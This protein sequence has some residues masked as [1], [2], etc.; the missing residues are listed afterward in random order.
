MELKAPGKGVPGLPGWGDSR[1][2]RQ[3]EALKVLPNV[4]YTTGKNWVVYH[5]GQLAADIA[6]LERD[7]VRA[8]SRLRPHS[9]A[10]ALLLQSFLCWQ[11]QQPRELRDMIKIAAG[12]C[13]LLRDEVRDTLRL[14]RGGQAKALF[15]AHLADWQEWLFPDLSDDEFADAYAQTITFGLLL[16]RREG[17]IF[18]GLEIPDIGEKLAKRHML[19]GR[20]LSILTARPDRGR[21]VE[22]RSLVLQTMRRM[23]GVAD[24]SLWSTAGTYHWLYEEFLE[25][26]DPAIRRKTGAYYTPTA[27]TDFMTRFVDE[28]LAQKLGIKRGFA[29]PKVVVLDPAMGTGTFLQSILE[30]VY[31]SRCFTLS[32]RTYPLCVRSAGG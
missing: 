6:T 10:F 21:S 9:N 7:L 26:Y 14:E 8:G 1:D 28:V 18:E 15:T 24:W 19:V 13:Q 20:A 29:D 30:R 5:Y 3:W 12:L 2:R 27:V 32:V 16:A 25:A 23:I 22:E 17:V 31:Y 4:M 11:P